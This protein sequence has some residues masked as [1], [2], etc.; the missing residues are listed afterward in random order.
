MEYL[1]TE[2]YSTERQIDNLDGA[3]DLLDTKISNVSDEIDRLGNQS[4]QNIDD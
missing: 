2:I 4:I 1:Q 3:I